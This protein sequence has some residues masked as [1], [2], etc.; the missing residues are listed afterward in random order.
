M[1]HYTVM[2]TPSSSDTGLIF[3]LWHIPTSTM[4]VTTN[5]SHEV[6][7]RIRSATFDGITMAELMLNVEQAGDVICEQHL[8]ACM[9]KALH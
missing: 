8:G 3:T 7:N 6:M 9:L 4:L 2:K 5:V 1:R